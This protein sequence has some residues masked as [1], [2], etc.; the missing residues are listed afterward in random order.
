MSDLYTLSSQLKANQ[1]LERAATTHQLFAASRVIE[2]IEAMHR[3]LITSPTFKAIN[4]A[5]RQLT[6]SPT[7][8]AINAAHRQLTTSPTFKAINAAHRQLTTSPTFKAV[9][10]ARRQLDATLAATSNVL[11]VS[12]DVSFRR[13]R[14]AFAVVK[15]RKG[16]QVCDPSRVSHH[17]ESDSFSSQHDTAD[18]LILFDSLVTDGLLRRTTR[19]LFADGHYA[20][21]VQKAL[22]CLNNAVK[23][24]SG[25]LE[26]DG[27]DLMRAAFSA[28]S[29][30]LFLNSL[31]SL[32]NRDEQRGYM[33]LFAGAM[34]GVR[35][36]RVHEHD[37]EDDPRTALELLALANHLMRVLKST[38]KNVSLPGSSSP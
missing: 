34:T 14:V 26:K 7:F 8:K 2:T 13:P 3:Q 35:N 12:V 16:S 17:L 22:V 25:L 23:A 31:Q 4:A 32:S 37:F 5:H 36:P 15:H 20:I 11:P 18:G 1:A 30:R 24:K 19:R 21:A 33:D 28:K 27:A 38:I 9:D 6:T 10:A 29:P